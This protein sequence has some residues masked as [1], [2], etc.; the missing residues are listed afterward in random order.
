MAM[1]KQLCNPLSFTTHLTTAVMKS[2]AVF[3]LTLFLGASASGQLQHPVS[4]PLESSQSTFTTFRSLHSPAHSLRIT[5]QNS[6]ICDAHSAQYTG[7]LD[8]GPH[9]LFFWY[10]ESQRN[11][12]QDPLTLWMTGGPGGSSM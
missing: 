8:V 2:L 1:S 3:V 7:W 4:A 5:S 11:P 9:H 6:S 12:G 10:F